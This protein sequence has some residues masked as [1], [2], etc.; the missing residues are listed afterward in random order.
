MKAVVIIENIEKDQELLDKL[1]SD[2]SIVREDIVYLSL[3]VEIPHKDFE[4]KAIYVYDEITT[5]LNDSGIPINSVDLRLVVDLLLK[6]KDRE[7]S[8]TP[9]DKT[10]LVFL[11]TF[12]NM[13]FDKFSSIHS[14]LTSKIN[15]GGAVY[16]YVSNELSKIQGGM[17]LLDKPITQV[18][19]TKFE[20]ADDLFPVFKYSEIL[21][22]EQNSRFE[23]IS[24]VNAIV[25]G[26][27]K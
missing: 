27:K 24:F 15:T 19:P 26:E 23:H 17:I 22:D 2:K 11:R 10:G 6:P 13:Y 14:F 9:S 8:R 4:D 3:F 12:T 1:F 21:P 18:G 16:D 7:D 25:R 5:I 20:L